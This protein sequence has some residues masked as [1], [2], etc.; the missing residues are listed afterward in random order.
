MEDRV[1]RE[2]INLSILAFPIVIRA[3]LD[4]SFT[5]SPLMPMIKPK[6]LVISSGEKLEVTSYQFRILPLLQLF[7]TGINQSCVAKG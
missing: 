4:P 6:I 2:C 3:T 1:G 7:L 5:S